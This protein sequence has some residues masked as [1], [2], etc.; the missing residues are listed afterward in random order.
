M[1]HCVSCFILR[2]VLGWLTHHEICRQSHSES[3]VD[4]LSLRF[5]GWFIVKS[6]SC[7]IWQL[8]VLT[9]ESCVDWPI[10]KSVWAD[11]LKDLCGL[12]HWENSVNWLMRAIWTESLRELNGLAHC[13]NCGYDSCV[14]RNSVAIIGG[15][16]C[17]ENC[18]GMTVVWAETVAII[19]G[20]QQWVVFCLK[21]WEVIWVKQ[22]K[23]VLRIETG[24][25]CQIWVM[26][27]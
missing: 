22:H 13:E 12:T 1:N 4:W 9:H 17:C 18:V 11:S 19:G 6:V 24:K 7:L 21:L 27:I 14:D 16:A 23:S 5:V 10:V 3:C 20:L 2:S 15:L 26:G 25:Q 8:C